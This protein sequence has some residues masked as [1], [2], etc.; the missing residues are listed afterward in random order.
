MLPWVFALTAIASQSPAPAPA[1]AASLYIT[2]AW[3]TADGLPQN[4]VTS[5]VQTRDGYLWLGTF[6]GLVRFDGQA[7][8]V[9]DPAN[10][11]GLA[12]SRIV[13]LHEDPYRVLWIGTE[14]GL[15]RYEQGRFTS[16]GTREGLL[17]GVVWATL[18]D[19]RGRLWVGTSAGLARYD[20]RA[21]TTVLG[22]EAIT[23]VQGLAEGPDG[24][25]WVATASGVVRLRGGEIPTSVPPM[26]GAT[27][28]TRCLFVDRQAGLWAGSNELSRWDGTRFVEVPLPLPAESRGSIVTLSQ[29]TDGTLWIGTLRGGVFQWRDGVFRRSEPAPRLSDNSVRSVLADGRGNIWIGTE[30]GGLNRLK[31]RHVFSYQRPYSSEQS[32]G[33]IVDDGAGG[34]W[35]GA[36]CGGLLHFDGVFRRMPPDPRLDCIWALHRDPDGTLWI[37]STVGG[38]TRFSDGRIAASYGTKD[39]LLSNTVSGIA[40]DRDGMLWIGSAQGVNRW[41]GKRFTSYGVAQGLAHPVSCIFQDRHGALWFGGTAG[42]TKF[43]DGRFTRITTAQGLSN[44]H[45]R[46]IHQDADGVMWIGTYGGGLNRLKDG[47]FTRYGIREGLPD[48]AV[49]R[50]IE[51]GRGNLW[52]SGNKGVYRVARSQLNDFAEGRLSYITAVS[53][54]TADGM[55]IDETNGGQPA[56]W[57]TPDGRFWFPTIKGLVGIDPLGEG[58]QPPPVVVERAVVNGQSNDPRTLPPFGPG[59]TGAEFHY[60]AIDLGAAEKTRFRYRLEGYDDR[61]TDAGARRVAYY[62]GI[63]PGTYHFEVIATDSDG[64]WTATPARVPFVVK[65]FWWQRRAA[66]AAALL[67]LVAATALV[68]RHVVLRGERA[69]LAEV[70]R[71]RARER[72]LDQERSRIARDLHDDLGSR[73]THIGMMADTAEGAAVVPRIAAAA[74][75]AARTMDELVWAVNARN[76]TV[77]SFAHYLAH[78]A[79]EHVI[80]AGLRCRVMMPP[81]LPPR[82]LAAD[83]RRNLYLA[84]KEAVNN[85]V[86]HA[87]ADAIRVAFRI[88]G[89]TLAVEIADDGR[90]LPPDVDPTGNGLKNYRER[91]E[92]ARGTLAVESSPGAGTRV[93]F[94][95]PL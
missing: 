55:I 11:P 53:Y 57:R 85:A 26:P 49:S 86:K 23:P 5:M 71:D 19:T 61:W 36:T 32:I 65:P 7:F 89:A 95:V 80:P 90:G 4:T 84:C 45:V 83:V 68:A 22:G 48:T 37:G 8:T 69:R 2:R 94:R 9:F 67:L 52:M 92:A 40:R 13:S 16:Y 50:I 54:G 76:D 39:G 74:R 41:D 14:S 27:Q 58:A 66:V 24:D 62:T 17:E 25:V 47:R 15:T 75:D 21:F 73:L 44:D 12:S 33:P 91:M 20:G 72:A 56:G 78:F 1:P 18:R 28:V 3:G 31:R 93:T 81:D 59:T 34:L 30:V 64:A 51:D 79:E 42:L 60:T 10:S 82:P 87:Q 29:E 43:E 46:A 70:E 6:G 63:Q 35:I 77:E 38:L 88:D